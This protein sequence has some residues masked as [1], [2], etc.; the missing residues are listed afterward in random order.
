M[1]EER[2]IE[3]EVEAQLELKRETE[4]LH[5][6]AALRRERDLLEMVRHPEGSAR[7]RYDP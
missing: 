6:I 4:Y 7:D 1:G 5:R 3:A 2:R